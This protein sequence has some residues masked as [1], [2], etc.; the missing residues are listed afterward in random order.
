MLVAE[1]GGPGAEPLISMAGP[2]G[3]PTAPS[4][5]HTRKAGGDQSLSLAYP[6]SRDKA[7]QTPPTRDLGNAVL[8]ARA[9]A[10]PRARE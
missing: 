8:P 4:S 6:R 2:Y 9:H 5:E 1:S 3:S 10:W 7:F